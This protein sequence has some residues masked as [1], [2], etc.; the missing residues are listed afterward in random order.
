MTDTVADA[1]AQCICPD[2]EIRRPGFTSLRP[3]QSTRKIT[4]NH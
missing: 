1:A 3:M 2:L 4:D